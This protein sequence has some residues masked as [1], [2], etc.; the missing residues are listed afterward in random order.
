MSKPV[1]LRE[2]TWEFLKTY[3][4]DRY[5]DDE[6]RDQA[7][8]LLFDAGIMTLPDLRSYSRGMRAWLWAGVG[9]VHSRQAGQRLSRSTSSEWWR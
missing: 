8:S 3:A 2:D 5:S 6:L 7:A 4:A 9:V 1:N